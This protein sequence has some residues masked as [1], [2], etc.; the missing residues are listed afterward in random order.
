MPLLLA[1]GSLASPGLA[2]LLVLALVFL[3]I[4]ATK[5]GTQ[6]W[7]IPVSLLLVIAY[8]LILAFGAR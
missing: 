1:A 7:T 2:L 6:P 3:I 8:L 5:A 4:G